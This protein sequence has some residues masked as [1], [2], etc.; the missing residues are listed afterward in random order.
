VTGVFDRPAAETAAELLDAAMRQSL[1][2]VDELAGALQ[3]IDGTLG[4]WRAALT[5]AAARGVDA[6]LLAHLLSWREQLAR[7]MSVCIQSLQFHDRLMQQLR[8]VRHG[9]VGGPAAWVDPG[10]HSAPPAAGNIELF[11][12]RFADDVA[13][14]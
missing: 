11:D 5:E 12:H 2:P 10:E 3:R 14:R 13:A 6:E 1:G 4:T 7:E 9:L 8:C